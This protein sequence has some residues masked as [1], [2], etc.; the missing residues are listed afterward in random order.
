MLQLNGDMPDHFPGHERRLY[1]QACKQRQC[2]RKDGS[3]R[4]FRGT[5]ISPRQE[6]VEQ[7]QE[8]KAVSQNVE[9][10]VAKQSLGTAIFGGSSIGSSNESKNPF[11]I[12]ATSS[13]LNPFSTA[14]VTATSNPFSGSSLAAKPP[15]TPTQPASSPSTNIDTLSETFASKVRVSSVATS[16]SSQSLEP[17]T[18]WPPQSSFPPPYPRYHL[19]ADYETLTPEATSSVPN[20][21]RIDNDFDLPESSNGTS[22]SKEDKDAFESSLDRTFQK[23]ADRLA[24]NP[25]QILRYEFRGQP[26]L[27]SKSDAVGKMLAPHQTHTGDGPRVQKKGAAAASGMP[28]CVNCSADRVFEA[29]LT[30]QAIAELEAE[31]MGLEGMDWGTVILGVCGSDCVP[32]GTKIEDGQVGW[33]EEWVG[34]QWEEVVGKRGR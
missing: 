27:Y 13:T 9:E 8:T 26:L 11:S 3:I 31:E 4:G 1:L 6:K 2:R 33:V 23:F 24:Q 22:N 28:K 7:K 18:P 5:R 14:S 21:A 29:Q 34:V 25:E 16:Q 19:D 30:P 12:S 32:N 10:K 20:S 17:P 15:Q